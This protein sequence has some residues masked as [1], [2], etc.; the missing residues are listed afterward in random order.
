ML[1]PDVFLAKSLL[2]TI[3]T[4]T[5]CLCVLLILINVNC[6]TRTALSSQSNSPNQDEVSSELIKQ[7]A[8][9]AEEAILAQNE[10]LIS[11]DIQNSLKPNLLPSTIKQR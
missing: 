1:C 11:G 8:S 6:D 4:A 5:I 9:I 10:V 2:K 7:L 3:N